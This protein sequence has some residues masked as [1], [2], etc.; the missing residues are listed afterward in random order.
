MIGCSVC[1][2]AWP[3]VQSSEAVMGQRNRCALVVAVASLLG[4]YPSDERE[5]SLPV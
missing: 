3:G 4:E 5:E 2:T 1:K